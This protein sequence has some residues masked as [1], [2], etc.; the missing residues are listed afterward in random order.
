[1]AHLRGA[2]FFIDQTYPQTD[3]GEIARIG[4]VAGQAFAP[5]LAAAVDTAWPGRRRMGDHG[6]AFANCLIPAFDESVIRKLPLP[7]ANGRATA[8][9][10]HPFDP[11][12]PGRFKDIV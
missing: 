8:G 10:D 9:V 3:N 6:P 1:M 5:D 12:L 7:A 11:C 2:V 4:E